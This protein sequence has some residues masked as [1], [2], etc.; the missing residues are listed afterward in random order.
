MIKIDIYNKI[1]EKKLKIIEE[2]PVILFS[3]FLFLS[4]WKFFGVYNIILPPFC[5]LFFKVKKSQDFNPKELVKNYLLILGIAILAFLAGR[6]IFLGVILNL[7]VP[8]FIV[9]FLTNKFTPKA[10]FIYGM[11][12]V[13][14]QLVELPVSAFPLRLGALFYSFGL[15]TIGLHLHSKYIN[16]K[17]KYEK[18]KGKLHIISL[19]FKKISCDLDIEKEK[20]DIRATIPALTQLIYSTRNYKYLTNEYGKILYWFMMIFQRLLY[21]IENYQKTNSNDNLYFEKLAEVFEKV[22][23]ELGVIEN[24]KILN[25]LE[26][27]LKI[28]SPLNKKDSSSIKEIILLMKLAISHMNKKIGNKYDYNWKI[29][30]EKRRVKKLEKDSHLDIFQIR[31]A[32]RLSI[33]LSISFAFSYIS[34]LEHAYWLPMS[35][36]LMLMPYAEESRMKITNRVLGTISG[37]II[38]WFFMSLGDST[39]YRIVIIIFMTIFMYTAPITSWTM[40]M[41]TTCYGMTL[42]TMA[43]KLEEASI[44][45]ISYVLLA[46]LLTFFANHYILPNTSKREFLKSIEELFETDKKM[47]GELRKNIQSSSN[48]VDFRHLMMEHNMLFNE[49]KTYISKNLPEQ[50]RKLY[51]KMLEINNFLII[52]IEQLNSYIHYGDKKKFLDDFPI[53]EEIFKNL[54]DALNRIA[55]GY[56]HS[57][58]ESS[59]NTNNH[60]LFGKLADDIYF[61]S[62]VISSMKSVRELKI[63]HNK[64]TKNE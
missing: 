43:L 27:F 60:Q 5:T 41:Y 15:L 63:L 26:E 57:Q 32:L 52:E 53:L 25:E 10:Y 31:F 34:K 51:N 29:S 1:I 8:F 36:F 46:T 11:A 13:F 23:N 50:D 38:C 64:C 56:T 2:F 58:L 42:A 28:P 45:R 12:F 21:F 55:Y 22:G 14:M 20:K 59:I 3:I 9:F 17:I 54:E 7:F 49:I 24:E 44:L 30:K 37:I 40:T 47:I 48:I 4:L 39:I 19:I 16:K 61:N 33:V 35:S 18:L 6:N 62:L